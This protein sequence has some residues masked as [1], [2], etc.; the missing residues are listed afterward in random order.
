MSMRNVEYLD[1]NGEPGVN[2]ADHYIK[3]MVGMPGEKIQLDPNGRLIADGEVVTEPAVFRRN[4]LR[5]YNGSDR[6]YGKTLESERGFQ[7]YAGLWDLRGTDAFIQIAD[8]EYLPMGDNTENSLDGRA[9][10][11]IHEDD[12][13]S[14]TGANA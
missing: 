9:F 12:V 11:A 4:Y 2:P 5:K 8:E 13:V 14:N 1:R 7:G 3:R 6:L 10:G